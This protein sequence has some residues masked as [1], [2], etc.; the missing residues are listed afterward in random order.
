MSLTSVVDSNKPFFAQ[1]VRRPTVRP[2]L[3]ILVEPTRDPSL[4]G[5]AVDYAFRY[6]CR[7]CW[8]VEEKEAVAWHGVNRLLFA[9]GPRAQAYKTAVSRVQ[10]AERRMDAFEDVEDF[11][12][13]EAVACLHLA[14]MEVFARGGPVDRFVHLLEVQ[15]DQGQIDEVVRMF[16]LVTWDAFDPSERMLLNPTFGRGSDLVDGA[17]ADL[18]I[19]DLL[20]EIKTL[21]KS[22]LHAGTIRQLVGYA[23]LANTYGVMGDTGTPITRLGVWY[24]RSG[25]FISWD[26]DEVCDAEGQREV[27]RL[28]AGLANKR[29]RAS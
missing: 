28:F 13:E 26:L 18:V 14:R 22:A 24:A 27:A 6:G 16:G 10:A 2:E 19:D 7:A 17:D 15:P 3:P 9:Y 11:G 4:I 20:V 21:K 12:P 5:S 23:V 29:R 25:E 1:H 8:D